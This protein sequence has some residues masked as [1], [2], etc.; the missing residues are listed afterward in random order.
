MKNIKV[1]SYLL[2]SCFAIISF[3]RC[4]KSL[5]CNSMEQATLVNLTG[6]DGCGWVIELSDGERLEPTNLDQF[7]TSPSPNQRVCLKYELQPDLGSIC[8][9][10]PFVEIK[11]LR[12]R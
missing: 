5:D 1:L 8:M 6:L 11:E 3:S 9:V 10:G 12:V 2:I 7:V 4:D